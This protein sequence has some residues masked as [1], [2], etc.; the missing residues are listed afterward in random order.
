MDSKKKVS[1]KNIARLEKVLHVLRRVLLP[2]RGK[3]CVSLPNQ[4][5]QHPRCHPHHVVNFASLIIITCI[6]VDVSVSVGV[7]VS[8]GVSVAVSVTYL[9]RRFGIWGRARVNVRVSDSHNA[10][11]N[12]SISSISDSVGVRVSDGVSD[13]D[14]IRR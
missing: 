7:G 14:S 12:H 1:R 3:L 4:V 10:S 6:S 8:T 9:K 13:S 2:S 11:D 5:L